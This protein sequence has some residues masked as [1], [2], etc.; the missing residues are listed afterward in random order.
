[1][2]LLLREMGHFFNREIFYLLWVLMP[3]PKLPRPWAGTEFN[4]INVNY[5]V[6][7][8]KK[9]LW[10]RGPLRAKSIFFVCRSNIAQKRRVEMVQGSKHYKR[11][12][13]QMDLITSCNNSFCLFKSRREGVC[14]LVSFNNGLKFGISYIFLFFHI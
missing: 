8:L 4:Y 3:R 5:V 12:I 11:L 14:A 10:K 1:M 2:G 13:W 9:N 7:S 6:I